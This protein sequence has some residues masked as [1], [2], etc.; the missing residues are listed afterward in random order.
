MNNIKTMAASSLLAAVLMLFSLPSVAQTDKSQKALLKEIQ[1]SRDY[2]VG[3]GHGATLRQAQE[4]ALADLA[5]QIST[6]VSSQFD[7]IMEQSRSKDAE[8]FNQQVNS[9]V[10]TYSH[11]TLRNALEIIVK[12]EPEAD[13]VRYI[14]AADIDKVFEDRKNKAITFARNAERF[15]KDGKV[16]DA[17]SYYY[18]ALSL[19]RSC[20]SGDKIKISFGLNEEQQLLNYLYGRMKECLQGVK[21]SVASNTVE[22]DDTRTIGLKVD[23]KSL[24]AVNFNYTYYNGTRRSDLCTLQNGEDIISIPSNMSL[25]KLDLRAEYCCEEEANMDSELRDVLNNTVQAPLQIAKMQLQGIKDVKAV[26]ASQS[27]TKLTVATTAPEVPAVA[28]TTATPTAT[29]AISTAV[30]YLTEVEAAPFLAT[31]VQVEKALRSKSYASVKSLFTEEGYQMFEKLVSY[32]N[33]RLIRNPEVRFSRFGSEITCRSFPMSFSFKT[34]RRT[35]SEN[36]VF[37]LND[38]ALITE[39]AFGLEERATNDIMNNSS[40]RYSEEARQVLV[41][42]LESYKTAY[43]LGRI[44]YLDKIFSND[45]LIITGTVVTSNGSGELLPKEQRHVKYT[46]QTKAQYLK[47]LQRT[48]LSNEF[49][50]IHFADNIVRKSS[51]REYYGIQIKQDYFSSSYGDTGYLFLLID[52][53]KE[54]GPQPIVKV[55]AWQPD[56]DP[57][58]QDGRLDMSHFQF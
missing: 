35:F 3:R 48:M 32:G 12:D 46:R 6:T 11:T 4:N 27:E 36:V 29:A 2:I 28:G 9:I 56:L 42:F 49:I 8:S 52:L 45:A 25:A 22:D 20:P 30:N 26:K 5:G 57:T 19:L 1:S 33:A 40:K 41:S 10:K 18:W 47:N 21:V 51:G 17:L 58:I 53:T 14:K 44:D 16:G 43:A 23:Y 13:V 50:N 15:E 55:R 39:V 34:N 24:P 37:R 38:D 31:M 54:E 7:Y